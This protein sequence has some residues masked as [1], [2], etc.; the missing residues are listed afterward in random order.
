[1]N[2]I[3][4][5]IKS[6]PEATPLGKL[7]LQTPPHRPPRPGHIYGSGVTS[8]DR[9]HTQ[10]TSSDFRHDGSSG[11]SACLRRKPMLSGCSTFACST[12]LGEKARGGVAGAQTGEQLYAA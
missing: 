9:L 6:P 8:A 7:P 2:M 11:V 1:M 10:T 12:F 3:T 4:P 5:F